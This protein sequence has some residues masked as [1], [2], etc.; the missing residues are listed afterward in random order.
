MVIIM[1]IAGMPLVVP[2]GV[3]LFLGSLIPLIGMLVA[4]VVVILI[5]L[6]TKGAVMALVMAIALVLTV[7]LEGNLLN[8]LILGK[9][10]QI[11]P[12]AI[13]VTVTA[14]TIVGGIFGAFVAV[15]LVAILNNVIRD[16][17]ARIPE[18]AVPEPQT[19]EKE[20]AAKPT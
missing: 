5:A 8:P 9:A 17:H 2:L 12:L 6:V 10:V 19:P 14:G 15:P 16:L 13:L 7:Q 1:I 18:Q 20:P 4:G 3:L 11:H